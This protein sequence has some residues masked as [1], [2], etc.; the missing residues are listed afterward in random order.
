MQI[1]KDFYLNRG[2]YNVSIESSSARIIDDSNFQLIF[3][4]NAGEKFFF[5]SLKLDIP[6]D[7][8]RNNFSK[9]DVLFE[10]LKNEPYSYNAIKKILKEVEIIA[11][12]DEYDSI[13]A[14]VEEN[15]VGKNKLNFKNLILNFK[16]ISK[17]FIKKQKFKFLHF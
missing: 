16:I 7:Y 12:K 4:I 17:I 14:F 2:Y 9:I 6:N 1:L 10:K 8:N 13:N 15:I 11:L 3:N 5:N